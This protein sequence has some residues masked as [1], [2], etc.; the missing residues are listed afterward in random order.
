M[1]VRCVFNI[2]GHTTWKST[3]TVLVIPSAMELGMD[4]LSKLEQLPLGLF[5]QPGPITPTRRRD[6][7]SAKVSLDGHGRRRLA[8]SRDSK[9]DRTYQHSRSY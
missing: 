5:V 2:T 7:P 1:N 6:V 8:T 4:G 3:T 9:S